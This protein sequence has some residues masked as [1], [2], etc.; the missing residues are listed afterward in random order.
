MTTIQKLSLFIIFSLAFSFGL[1]MVSMHIDDSGSMSD[2]PFS[3]AMAICSMSFAEH[4]AIFKG[5]FAAIS[6]KAVSWAI[7]IALSLLIIY[8]K[9]DPKI[10][11]PS[12]KLKYFVKR[13]FGPFIFN[14]ILIALSDGIIQPKLYA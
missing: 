2:C 7:L 1:G 3:D 5:L 10:Y 9:S 8:F 4:I 13:S 12:I 14:K 11:S 6:S